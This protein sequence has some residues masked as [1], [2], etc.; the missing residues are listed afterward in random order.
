MEPKNKA[1]E[2]VENYYKLSNDFNKCID[3]EYNK[4][5]AIL[6]VEQVRFFH[7]RLFY[8][9]KGS[10]FDQYLDSVKIEIEKL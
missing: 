2:I 9:S 3:I 5:C 6:T 10:I 4:Q 7:E 8:A 1:I